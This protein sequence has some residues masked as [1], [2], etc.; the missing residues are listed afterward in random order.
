MHLFCNRLHISHSGS[1]KVVDFGTNRNSVC[2]FLLV[3][4]SNFLGKLFKMLHIRKCSSDI[5]SSFALV[6]RG[7]QNKGEVASVYFMRHTF[8]VVT[9]KRRLKSAGASKGTP[10]TQ[11]ASQKSSGGG[12]K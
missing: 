4:N 3:I 1:S 6:D 9:V 11:N 5:S 8:L 10:A 2:D 7:L 12:Q